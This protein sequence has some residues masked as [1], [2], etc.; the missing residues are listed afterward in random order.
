MSSAG[1]SSN[2]VLRQPP[3]RIEKLLEL[4][5]FLFLIVPSL[6]LPFLLH[7]ELDIGFSELA[8]ATILRDIALVLLVLFFLW[9]NEEPLS[10]IGWVSKSVGREALIGT[11]L[12]VPFSM[13]ASLLQAAL[14]TAGLSLPASPPPALV[15]GR[16]I[17]NILLSVLLVLVVALAEETIFRGYLL[18]RLA[19]ISGSRI[20][21]V[22]VS[23]VV[24]SL[25]H[26]YEGSAGVVTVGVMGVA[27]SLVLLWRRSLVAPITI[28]FLQD[29]AGVV[30]APFLAGR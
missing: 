19:E 5:V 6:V 29:F 3:G 12:F 4:S 1:E 14:V 25:G 26:H 24:F 16:E 9:R 15:P 30:L 7:V 27:F 8:I 13:G 11:A 20:V 22:L 18:A 21:A 28:H 17:V 23:S 2:G 10:R